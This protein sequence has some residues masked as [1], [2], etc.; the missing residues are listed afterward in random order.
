[1]ATRQRS[2]CLPAKR[3]NDATTFQN[4]RLTTSA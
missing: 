4:S 2:R 1:M 3:G